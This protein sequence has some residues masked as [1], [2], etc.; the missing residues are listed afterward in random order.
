LK[1][2][3]ETV[4]RK[5]QDL[6]LKEKADLVVLV[7]K[8]CSEIITETQNL[9]FLRTS[10]GLNDSRSS[11]FC[12]ARY[13]DKSILDDQKNDVHLQPPIISSDPFFYRIKIKPTPN[14]G[15][16][17]SGDSNILNTSLQRNSLRK[18]HLIY[19]EMLSP[20]TTL[21]LVQNIAG[22]TIPIL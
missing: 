6:F 5:Q 18:S 15:N 19:P 16:V 14:G 10:N 22:R 3:L 12:D 1:T 2:K 17:L 9:I 8:E 21:E 11:N 7:K 13:S 20:E 4:L